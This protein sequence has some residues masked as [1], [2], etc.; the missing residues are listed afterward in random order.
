VGDSLRD[1]QPQPAC[2]GIEPIGRQAQEHR[3]VRHFQP[4]EGEI[5]RG[6][7]GDDA[8]AVEKV[9][10]ALSRGQ[11]AGRFAIGLAELAVGGAAVDAPGREQDK[12]E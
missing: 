8:R 12:A 6:G 3:G 7:A 1:E 5:G 10:M 9:S 11:H 4:G 2:V